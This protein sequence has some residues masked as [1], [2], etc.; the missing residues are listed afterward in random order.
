M[1]GAARDSDETAGG[2][3]L[4]QNQAETAG[5]GIDELAGE[6]L[7]GDVWAELAGFDLY[8]EPRSGAASPTTL[9]RTLDGTNHGAG[10]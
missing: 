6:R 5:R 8:Q 3:G 9:T 10:Y 1:Q 7:T 2:H 4:A